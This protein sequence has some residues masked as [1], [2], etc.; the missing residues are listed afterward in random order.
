M[1]EMATAPVLILLF[2][3][4][5]RDKYEKEPF[6]LLTWGVICGGY[7]AFVVYGLGMAMER[8]FPHKETPLYTAFLS[9]ALVEEG[10][11]F[12]FL[13]FLI[14]RNKEFNEPFDGIVYAVFVSLGFAWIEN[15]VYVTHPLWGGIGTAM[16]RAFISVPAHGLFGVQMGFW[17]GAYRFANKKYGLVLAFLCAYVY[18]GLY[19]YFLLWQ[20]WGAKICFGILFVVLCIHSVWCMQYFLKHSPFR[21]IG[22]FSSTKR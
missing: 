15:M 12:L 4:Y 8:L 19:N 11:K 3:C 13:Y 18:H 14:C 2:Y 5:I 1:L 7:V 6:K 17:F 22:E 9:S 21:P 10:I 16:A 20:W